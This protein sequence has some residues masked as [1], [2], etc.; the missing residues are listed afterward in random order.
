MTPPAAFTGDVGH[1]FDP[2][3]P[4]YLADPYPIL[5]ALRERV[6]VFYAPALDM[7]VVTR[8]AE[9]DEI[10][11]NPARFSAA[12]AQEPIY[13]LAPEARQILADG[14]GFTPSMS[15]CDPPKHTRIRAHNVRAFSARRMALLEPTIRERTRELVD[16]MLRASPA[17]FIAD[18]AFPL[19]ALTIFTLVGFPD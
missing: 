8:F 12:N 4:D 10:F 19:P 3:A 9:I 7:W 16:R 1:D 13:P 6:P 14:F 17:D 18:L 5:E 2:F 15:N 11:R